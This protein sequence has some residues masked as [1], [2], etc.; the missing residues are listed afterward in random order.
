MQPAVILLHGRNAAPENILELV[1]RLNRPHCRYLAPAAPNRSW[2]PYSFMAPI[3]SN[4]PHLSNALAQVR[5]IV[6]EVE[7]TGVPKGRIAILGFSQGACLATEFLIRNAS[8]FGGLIAFSGGAIGPPGTRWDFTGSFDGTPMFFGCS[9]TDA[10][11]PEARVRE[12]AAVVERMGARVTTKIYPGMGHVV[13][14]DEIA[15][16]QQ[17][18][19]L[20]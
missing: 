1:P 16:A 10:H 15:Q 14:D 6:A 17:I 4:E 5:A 20:L 9:D 3:E 18:L 12:S 7:A 13:S 19:D 11:V 2:Y 8:R